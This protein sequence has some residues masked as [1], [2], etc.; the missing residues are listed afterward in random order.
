M[1]KPMD[2][3]NKEFKRVMRGYDVEEVD[4]FLDEIIVD[5]EKMQRELDVLKTQISNYS[6]NMNNYREKELS[7]NNVMLSAQRFADQLTVDAERKAAEIIA[8]AEREAEKIVGSTQ[9]KYNQVLADYAMLA[10]RYNDAK[11]TLRDYF[12]TQLTILDQDE[13]GIATEQ[14]AEYIKQAEQLPQA[15]AEAEKKAMAE[16]EETKLNVKLKE[17]MENTMVSEPAAE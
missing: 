16:N 2:I 15:V 10:N 4:E 9:E 6:E 8:N 3:H 14:V 7:L 17:I 12:R 5:F 1:L 11:E 13:A